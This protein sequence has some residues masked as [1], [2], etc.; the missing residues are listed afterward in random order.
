MFGLTPYRGR[1]NLSKAWM[2]IDNM[3]DYMFDNFLSE[4]DY[5]FSSHYPMKVD[6]KDNGDKYLLEAELPGIRKEDINIEIR[7]DILT[8][9]VE[10]NE[11]VKE[12]RE[13]YIRRERRYGALRRSFAVDDVDQ[14]KIDAR[15][16]NGI[17]YMELPKLKD[18]K[19]K[20][21]RIN[22]R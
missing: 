7:D 3:F 6:I 13:N 19:G 2:D 14:D 11:E 1:R 20:V 12:E 9:S 18:V 17:L 15:F 21:N 16:E 5:R 22:I 10:T 8:I 4:M